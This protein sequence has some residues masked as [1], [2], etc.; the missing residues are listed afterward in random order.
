MYN[1]EIGLGHSPKKI[2]GETELYVTEFRGCHDGIENLPQPNS[3]VVSN[4]TRG[5][6]N[7]NWRLTQPV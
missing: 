7:Q 6:V 5:S 1:R 3:K 2:F 4:E